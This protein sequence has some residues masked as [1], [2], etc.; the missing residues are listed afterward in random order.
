MKW[1]LNQNT[2]DDGFVAR[3]EKTSGQNISS[4]YQCGKCSAGC[5]V[6]RDM[7]LAPNQIMRFLQLGIR[8]TVLASRTIWLCA[9]CQTCSIR[10]PQIIDLARVMDSLRIISQRKEMESAPNDWQSLLAGIWNRF[11][12]SMIY[13]LQMDAR[14]N[15][16]CFNHIFL[17]SIHYYG[18]VFEPAL[19]FN[20]NINSGYLFSNFLK[21]PVMLLKSKIK[22]LPVEVRRRDK[23]QKIFERVKMMEREEE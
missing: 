21:A 10:C 12:E 18:R 5:P 8:D 6:C 4:C 15:L 20:Y 23:V 19:I 11:K 2:T 22:F 3:V 14:S 16:R 13:I 17:D 9:S 1:A 7:D